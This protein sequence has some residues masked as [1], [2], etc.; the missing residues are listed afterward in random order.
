MGSEIFFFLKCLSLPASCGDIVDVGQ[1]L[2]PAD[3]PAKESLDSVEDSSPSRN[4]M[5][6][7]LMWVRSQTE[8]PNIEYVLYG[9]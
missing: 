9:K 8:I 3:R 5:T 1:T 4:H 6:G 7:A 2:V